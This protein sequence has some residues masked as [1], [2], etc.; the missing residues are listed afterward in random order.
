MKKIIVASMLLVAGA[1][2]ALAT[3]TKFSETDL[4]SHYID[5]SSI[6]REGNNRKVWI[7]EELVIHGE[8]GELSRRARFEFDC[9]GERFNALSIDGYYAHD[10]VGDI[11]HDKQLVN[12][13]DIPPE[14][15]ALNIYKQICR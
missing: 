12:W 3:W 1:A 8:R 14:S 13:I 7:K 6:R 5:K 9:K 11:Y 15:V 4:S 10:L 2:P